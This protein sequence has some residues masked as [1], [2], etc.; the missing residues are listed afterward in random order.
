ME[1]NIMLS[2][3]YGC[4]IMDTLIENDQKSRLSNILFT[5]NIPKDLR[6]R[7]IDWM[8]EVIGAFKFSEESFFTT[9]RLMDTFFMKTSKSH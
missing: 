9:V 3:N 2:K 1:E 6:C 8:I 4:D 7:M 5:H